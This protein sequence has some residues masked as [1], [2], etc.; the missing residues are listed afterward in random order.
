MMFYDLFLYIGL[1]IAIIYG[2]CLI[3][4]HIRNRKHRNIAP[5]KKAANSRAAMLCQYSGQRLRL[6]VMALE[7]VREMSAAAAKQ[8]KA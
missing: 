7:A 5:S 2:I 6:D 1:A 4:K 3:V 8:P